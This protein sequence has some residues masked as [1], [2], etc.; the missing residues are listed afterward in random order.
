MEFESRVLNTNGM[1]S[2]FIS[3]VGVL[4]RIMSSLSRMNT[5]A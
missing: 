3:S 2:F 1:I 4:A 5:V